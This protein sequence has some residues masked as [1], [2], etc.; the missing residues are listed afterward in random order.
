ME[1]IFIDLG[2]TVGVSDDSIFFNGDENL[3]SES[4]TLVGPAGPP[5]PQGPKGDPGRD[6]VDGTAATISVGTTTTGLPGT[7][8]VV[9]NTGTDSAAVLNF[10]IPRGEQGEQGIQGEQGEPGDDGEAATIQVGTVTTVAPEYPATVTNSGT[11]SAA[12]LN[13]VIPQGVQGETGP[14]GQDGQDGAPG[15]AATVTVGTTTTGAAG[16]NASVTNSGTSSAAVFNFTIPRGDT[17]AAGQDGQDGQDGAAA[18][19]TVG[20]TTTGAAGTNASVTNSGTSSAAV[21]NF[22]IPRGDTGTPGITYTTIYTGT[23]T[24]DV[25]LNQSVANFDYIEIYGTELGGRPLYTKLISPSVN[26]KFAYG[27][28]FYAGGVLY[29][30]TRSYTFT[31]NTKITSTVDSEQIEIRTTGTTMLASGSITITKVVGI[32]VT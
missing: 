15:Q 3:L 11:S 26:T 32:K 4:E 27:I 1:N 5:G 18:T 31:S 23:G 12:V 6:G 10:T 8:A 22:T 2:E 28:T 9:V 20:T 16:T 30:R 17:G 14:A 19:V 21:L 7:D 13:F 24:G 29:T 25:D